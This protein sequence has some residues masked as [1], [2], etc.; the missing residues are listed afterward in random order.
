[1]PLRLRQRFALV[2]CDMTIEKRRLCVRIVESVH[3]V[4]ATVWLGTLLATGLGAAIA[5]P[6]MRS[7]KPTVTDYRVP[8]DQHWLIVAG[9]VARPLFSVGDVASGCC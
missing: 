7:L 3:L 8:E 4:S 9:H 1:P 5:F 2:S 6:S